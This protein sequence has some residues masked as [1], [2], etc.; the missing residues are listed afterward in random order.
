MEILLN[1]INISWIIPAVSQIFLLIDAIVYAILEGAID[2]FF[3]IGSLDFGSITGDLETVVKNI[4]T[5]IGIFIMFKA[6]LLLIQYL[7]EPDKF[8]DKNQ[9]G[10]NLIKSVVI[11]ISL[12]VLLNTGILFGVF[13]D[14]QKIVFGNGETEFELLGDLGFE[15]GTEKVDLVQRLVF[16]NNGIKNPG[17]TVAVRIFEMFLYTYE[18]DGDTIKPKSWFENEASGNLFS[19][20]AVLGTVA[21]S[22]IGG[23]SFFYLLNIGN[24]INGFIDLFDNSY[25]EQYT[26]ILST[27]FGIYMLFTFFKYSVQL[28]MRFFKLILLQMLSPIAIVSYIT[29]DGKKTFKNFWSTYFS[30]YTELFIRLLVIY[31]GIYLMGAV[32]T[33]T[34]N[35]S[36]GG[37]II[38]NMV[39]KIILLSA[40]SKFMKEMPNIIAGLFGGKL[41]DNQKSLGSIFGGILGAGIGTAIGIGSARAAGAKGWGAAFG[42]LMGGFGG[43]KSGANSQNVG[44]FVSGQISNASK[45]TTRGMDVAGAGG[46][47]S[48]LQMQADRTFGGANKI[49]NEY[50][51]LSSNVKFYQE[52]ASSIKAVQDSGRIDYAKG[53]GKSGKA[54]YNGL[55]FDTIDEIVDYDVR[56]AFS[57]AE[58]VLADNPSGEVLI[59]DANGNETI[60]K[61]ANIE[62]EKKK[63]ADIRRSYHEDAADL[64][65]TELIGRIENG[66]ADINGKDK[67]KVKTISAYTKGKT[68]AIEYS[69]KLNKDVSFIN[70]SDTKANGT[71]KFKEQANASTTTATENMNKLEKWSKDQRNRNIMNGK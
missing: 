8:K 13:N 11:T 4:N 34:F 42:G 33:N 48:Y 21:R 44:A 45:S 49:K 46:F 22:K 54:A 28:V 66:G 27:V 32:L 67:E 31:L 14:L 53:L 39:L 55:K 68:E 10:E 57:N 29:P 43:A 24:P 52:N 59:K 6:S 56:S 15:A 61:A 7:V 64:A 50:D 35:T 63:F 60:I 40:I 26:A 25:G 3:M 30:T 70:V 37:N 58:K 12:L 69:R 16:G 23:V 36:L 65:T 9:G 5:L 38:A 62:S 18:K 2:I 71:I 17:H 41:S 19:T 47:A 1:S 51:E 20:E